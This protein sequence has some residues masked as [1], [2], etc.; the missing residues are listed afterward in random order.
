MLDILIVDDEP[1]ARERLK[2]LCTELGYDSFFEAENGL[3]AWEAIEKF[4][5]A[6]V[7]LDVEMPGENGLET[8]KKIAALEQPP[9]I[10]FTTAYEQYALEAFEAFASGYLLKPIKSEALQ[11][12]LNQAAKPTKVQL[13]N[14]VPKEND[15][16]QHITI[17]NHRGVSLIK[18]SEV[19]C[20]VADQKYI[21]IITTEGEALID[22]TLKELEKEYSKSFIRAHRNALVSK[23]HILGLDRDT[24]GHYR[25]RLEDVDTKPLISR[26]YIN[27]L[28]RFLMG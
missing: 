14:I 17:K 12:A 25:V 15:E 6:I 22:N 27:E 16:E 24:D 26:R 8:G 28:K 7:L 4:D 10:I 2:R 20:F 1:L 9:A 18:L 11:T 19:R 21:R 3:E 13:D 23:N 5:P